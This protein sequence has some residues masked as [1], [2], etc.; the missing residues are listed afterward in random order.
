MVPL[1]SCPAQRVARPVG[2]NRARESGKSL[3]FILDLRLSGLSWWEVRARLGV[4]PDKVIIALPRNPGPPYGKAHG[5][6]KN[7]RGARNNA[8]VV[9]DSEFVDWIGARVL[10]ATYG[11]EAIVVLEARAAGVS[12]A[13]YTVKKKKERAARGNAIKAQPERSKGK[14]KARKKG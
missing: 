13:D 12:L 4:T 3:R 2:E 5:H 9:T 7:K 11:V 1:P 10:S 8:L 6:Y 14:G